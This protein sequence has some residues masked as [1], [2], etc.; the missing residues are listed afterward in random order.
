LLQA[1]RTANANVYGEKKVG[2][3][4]V[5]G[6]GWGKENKGKKGRK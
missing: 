1:E 2:K 5:Q 6:K 3:F 4:K